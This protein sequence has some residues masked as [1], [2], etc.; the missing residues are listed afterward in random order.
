MNK[1]AKKKVCD[2]L[3]RYRLKSITIGSLS[4]AITEM[5][6]T[7][8][9]FNKSLNNN[10]VETIINNL[11]LREYILNS[12]GF[13]YTDCN[14]RLLFLNESLNNEEKVFVLAHE[15]GHI[16]F[17]HIKSGTVIGNDV[18]EEYE[19]NEFVHHLLNPPL[20]VKAKTAMVT[21]KKATISVLIVML[22]AFITFTT[23]IIVNKEQSYYG[24][25]YI[26]T[27]GHKYHKKECIH[28]KYKNNISRLSKED[29][30]NGLYEACDVC[31]PDEID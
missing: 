20:I 27:S 6:Y 31:L 21:H 30:D 9:L 22:I 3:K 18:K 23:S 1:I 19:A 28:V 15:I 25:F 29:F 12:R 11:K 8:I 2:F 24:E 14:Y 7:I 17:N 16:V 4:K 26:T 10:D 13:I 5:G